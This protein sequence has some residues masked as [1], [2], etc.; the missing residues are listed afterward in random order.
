LGGEV[1]VDLLPCL[2]SCCGRNNLHE[3]MR[4]REDNR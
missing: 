4:E 1:V 2:T 3:D